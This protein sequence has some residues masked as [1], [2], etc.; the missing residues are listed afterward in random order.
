MGAPTLHRA[1][2]NGV[3]LAYFEWGTPSDEPTIFLVHAT[4]FHARVWDQ[5][6]SFLGVRH[7]IALD[8][9]CHGRSENAPV[10][11]WTVFGRDTAEVI[12]SLGL[13]G[14]VG[15]GHSMG[16]HAIT[17]AAAACSGAF[18]RLVLIDPVIAAPEAYREG[19]AKL[20]EHDA[21]LHPTARRRS[22]FASVAEMVTRLEGRSGYARFLPAALRDYCE[23]GLIP[24]SDGDGLELACPP[25]LEAAIYVTSRSNPAVYESVRSLTIPVMILR[26][27]RGP[28][29]AATMDFSS[30]PTWP[31]L[32]GE[33]PNA[34][35]VYFP[36]YSH[37]LPMEVPELVA[38]YVLGTRP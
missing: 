11:N 30:S 6:I 22:R 37:F 3:E 15:V 35:E 5:M 34:Q 32:V 17:E 38:G 19:R 29:E 25:E 2:A 23:H 16:G 36:E 18:S 28:G 4:G 21:S 10:D 8:Q 1:R 12:R 9:R 14:A 31:G 7:V 24:A 26:A 13:S 33:F 27:R 20:G